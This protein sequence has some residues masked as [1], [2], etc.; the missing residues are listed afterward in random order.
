MAPYV[1]ADDVSCH[2]SYHC[3]LGNFIE[4]EVEQCFQSFLITYLFAKLT[5]I[6]GRNH[7]KT[8]FKLVDVAQRIGF[9][10]ESIDRTDFHTLT[11]VDTTSRINNCFAFPDSD[12][13]CWADAHTF[14]ATDTFISIQFY[15]MKKFF[16]FFFLFRHPV[17]P[18]IR[19][20]LPDMYCYLLL[21]LYTADRYSS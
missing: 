20:L 19:S 11:T 21:I 7:S 2:I 8:I 15:S 6:R 12:C 16:R 9:D 5:L 13:L 4:T 10:I 18:Q 17:C 14:R 1:V 3:L